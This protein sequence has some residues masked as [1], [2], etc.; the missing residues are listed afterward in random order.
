M[1]KK[2]GSVTWKEPNR[3]GESPLHIGSR[4]ERASTITGV[5]WLDDHRFVA[6]HRDGK[7]V[8][9][10]DLRARQNPV[11]MAELPNLT[12]SVDIRRISADAWELATS[13]CWA[14]AYS[15]LQLSDAAKPQFELQ[16][17]IWKNNRTFSHG[18]TFGPDGRL[19]LSMNVGRQPRIEIVGGRHWQLPAPWGCRSVCF[20]PATGQPYALACSNNPK[21]EAYDEVAASVW[22]LDAVKDEWIPLVMIN[23]MH[24]DAGAFYKGRLWI[25]DQHGDQVLG[26]DVSRHEKPIVIKGDF[27]FPHGVAVSGT[28]ILAVTNYGSSSITLIDLSSVPDLTARIPA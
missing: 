7:R 26:L 13:D 9:L 4:G 5:A 28:G 24:T 16:Q 14:G 2:L 17:T 18:A 6:N 12:D 1:I 21:R 19:W 3:T 15:L 23:K 20:N 11:A 10:F 8:A 22:T 27:C 25:N